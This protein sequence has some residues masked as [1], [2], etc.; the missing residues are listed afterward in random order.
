MA[1][2]SRHPHLSAMLDAPD[3]PLPAPPVAAG[4]RSQLA[5]YKV[6]RRNPLELWGRQA[7]EL[8]IVAGRFL[9]RHQVLVSDPDAI[10]HVLVDNH[11]NYGRSV[12]AKRVLRPVLGTGLLMA[13]GKAWRHQ[14]R[15]VAPSLAPRTMPILARHIVL[16]AEAKERELA[17]LGSRPLE[18]LPHL[19]QLA[20]S[21]AGQSMFSVET[22]GF[23]P[24]LRALLLRYASRY[25]QP[26]LLVTFEEHPR[27][28]YRDARALGWAFDQFERD[29]MLFIVFT[30]PEAFLCEL[31]SDQYG[32]LI[33]DYGFQR[34]VVDSLTQFESYPSA[35]EQAR[36]RFERVVNGLRREGVSVLM[37]RETESREAPFRVTP[38]E[39]LADTIIQLENRRLPETRDGRRT[40]L[41]EILKNR[42]S[43][44]SSSSHQFTIGP[45]GLAI[46]SDAHTR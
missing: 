30:S 41:L 37:T 40:R 20:L 22:A 27:R 11:E 7:Y 26:G 25:A 32:R 42:G 43:A 45:G 23:A 17:A 38:E 15:T 19:Q 2:L 36:V 31:V 39:Y 12:G 34:V 46:S 10:R 13:E 14:R 9:T 28:L 8:P 33:Q 1:R 24:A 44:H 6:L 4:R 29:R 21:I 35:S 5:T 3:Q 18:L 16:A